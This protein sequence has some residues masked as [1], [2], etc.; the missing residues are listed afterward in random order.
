MI[1]EKIEH[2]NK[3]ICIR[4]TEAEYKKVNEMMKH[5]NITKSI[6]IRGLINNHYDKIEEV[7]KLK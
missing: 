7:K 1:F 6:L 5:H 2:K 3:T 4:I